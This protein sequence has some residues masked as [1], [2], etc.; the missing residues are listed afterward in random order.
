M[1]GYIATFRTDRNQL[2]QL[3]YQTE[4]QMSHR[5]G[6]RDG[7]AWVVRQGIDATD[8]L[9]YGPYATNTPNGERAANF[10]LK[11]DQRAGNN[12]KVLT[13]EVYDVNADRIL[14]KREVRRNEFV[15]SNQ[16]QSFTL[17]FTATPGQ[18]LEYR[19]FWH[20]KGTIWQ[21]YVRVV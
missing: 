18:R 19:T 1:S 11:I 14:T 16:Y 4:T 7:N 20:G 10:R 3:T 8:F 6:I 9:A 17:D 21:D 5:T 15:Q 2:P 12:D 13:I